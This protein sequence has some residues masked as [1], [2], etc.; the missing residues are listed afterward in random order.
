MLEDVAILISDVEDTESLAE[1]AKRSKV[2]LNC[3]GPF[4][5]YGEAVVKACIENGA[6]YVDI[7]GEEYFLEKTQLDYHSKAKENKTYVIGACGFD[8]IPC[9]MGIQYLQQN[10]QGDLVSV[11]S[12]VKPQSGP[13]GMKYNFGS[14]LSILLSFEMI[15][16]MKHLR[17]KLF[18]KP[19]PNTKHTLES[20]GIL[21]YSDDVKGWCVPF[22][23][24]DKSVVQRTQR[25]NYELRRMRPIQ[26]MSYFQRS[27][28]F[29]ALLTLWL[30]LAFAVGSTYN[31]TQTM[32]KM[33]PAY[34]LFG[35]FS[36]IGPTREQIKQSKFSM[37]LVG[38]GYESK[39]VEP[40]DQ[41]SSPPSKKMVVQIQGPE[42][43]YDCTPVCLVQSALVI[44]RESDKLPESGGVYTPGAAFHKTSLMERLQKHGFSFNVLKN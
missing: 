2:V 23:G 39:L 43:G 44:L 18:P 32:F 1:M 17:E 28:F 14:F 26:T 9:E 40:E 21:F 8:S 33:S 34:Y 3:V 36:K 25:F 7:S 15:S 6:H 30:T 4:R 29:N 11:E 5:M 20:R 19:M 22:L 35:L 24:C 37:T 38:H 31:W 10:F 27:S 12:Y 16:E 41:H 13:A 42:P